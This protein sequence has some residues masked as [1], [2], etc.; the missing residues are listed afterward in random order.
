MRSEAPRAFDSQDLSQDAAGSPTRVM[1][2]RLHLVSMIALFAVSSLPLRA[3]LPGSVSGVV[4]DSS[5]VPQIGAVVQLLRPDMSVIAAVYTSSKGEFT[6]KDILPGRYAVKAMGASFLPSLRE[7][8]RVR[9]NTVVN[10]TLNTLFEVMQWLPAEPRSAN[11][12]QDDWEWTLRS[13]ANRPLLRWLEDGPLVVVSDRPGS[14]PKLKARLMATGQEGTFG[15]SG[16]RFTASVEDTPSESRELLARVDFAPDTDAGMESMLGFR[17]DLGFAGSVE[18][19]AAISIHP[20]IEGSGGEGLEEAAVRSSETIHLGDELEVDAGAQQVMARFLQDSPNT[21]LASLPFATVAWNGANS[22][23]SYQVASAPMAVNQ[24]QSRESYFLPRL[25][26]RNGQLA[27]EHG[28]HQEIGWQRRTDASA[29]SFAVY[30]DRLEN[31]VIEAS[32][33]T[34][35]SN[36]VLSDPISGLM[37]GA[38]Q[39]YASAGV[40]ATVEHRMT[41]SSNVR[42]SYASGDALVMP[43]LVHP[44][45]LSQVFS[46]AKPRH[47]QMYAISLSGRLDGTGTRWRASYRWQ[48]ADTVTRIAPYSVDAVAPFLSLHL[49]Q[50]VATHRDGLNIEALLDVNNLLAQGYRPYLLNGGLVVFAQDRRS[51]GAGVAFTF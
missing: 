16:E 43:A 41:G 7:N 49:R 2:R 30:A 47:A 20:V 27:L 8:V 37:H 46:A 14:R 31:P 11:A 13:A 9:T 25:S 5:G 22:T 6:F 32:G 23:V 45:A 18:S 50:P 35:A 40:T 15:E 24:D 42:M 44:T 29:M 39:N 4:R 28:L 36:D 51:L 26:V 12:K 1:M 38:G 48:P 33:R 10:L 21:I 19:M 34:A 3:A 17:Q